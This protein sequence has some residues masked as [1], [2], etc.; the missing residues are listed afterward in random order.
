MHPWPGNWVA[1][2]HVVVH[3]ASAVR[4]FSAGVKYRHC[5]T[6]TSTRIYIAT[7]PTHMRCNHIHT[8]ID[9]L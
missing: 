7:M 5:I 8:Y 6:Y 9:T 4:A 2:G 3:Y 1:I